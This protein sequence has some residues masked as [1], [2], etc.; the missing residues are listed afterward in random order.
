MQRSTIWL[1]VTAYFTIVAPA[2]GGAFL[3][4]LN[5]APSRDFATIQAGQADNYLVSQGPMRTAGDFIAS[6]PRG[7]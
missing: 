7:S 5:F 1:S 6:I 2:F 4:P 3:L